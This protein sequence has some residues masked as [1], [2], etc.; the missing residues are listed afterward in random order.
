MIYWLKRLEEDK[1]YVRVFR[2]YYRADDKT[3]KELETKN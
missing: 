1:E 3:Q 2:D